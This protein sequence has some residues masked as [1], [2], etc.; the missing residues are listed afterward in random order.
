MNLRL[1]QRSLLT[2][3]LAAIDTGIDDHLGRDCLKDVLH[4]VRCIL[5][6]Q[7]FN[8]GSISVLGRQPKDLHL[9]SGRVVAIFD[10]PSLYP[11]LTVRQSLQHA[12]LLCQKVV[13]TPAEVEK[14]LGIERFSDFRI[15]HLSLG[16]KRRASIAQALLGSPELVLLDEPFNGLDAEGVDDVLGLIGQLN[17]DEGT[18]F[19]LSSHQL[20]YL[21][22][23]CSHIAI[24]HRGEIALSS[25]IDSLLSRTTASVQLRTPQESEAIALL[26]GQTGCRFSHRDSGGSLH[27]AE[28][29]FEIWNGECGEKF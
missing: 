17:R 13:R 25:D 18:A 24:L 16:N 3:T 15:R 6:L 2:S 27:V 29:V 4:D 14:L 23:V 26:E 12:L 21:E 9:A 22:Q 10:T 11:N 20:P 7:P 28:V 8:S 1:R 5:G 19:L